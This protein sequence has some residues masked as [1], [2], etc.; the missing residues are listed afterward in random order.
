M[1]RMRRLAVAWAFLRRPVASPGRMLPRCWPLRSGQDSYYCFLVLV[2]IL[3]IVHLLVVDTR[4]F[5]DRGACILRY[6][7]RA[8]VRVA[9]GARGL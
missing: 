5:L 7:S 4:E 3:A 2:V 8:K 6:W 1:S 9:G